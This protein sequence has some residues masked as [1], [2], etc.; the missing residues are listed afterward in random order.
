MKIKDVQLSILRAELDATVI[1]T[2]DAV[3]KMPSADPR[4]GLHP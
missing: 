1:P 4:I 2:Q 3:D